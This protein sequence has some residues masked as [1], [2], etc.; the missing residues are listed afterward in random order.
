MAECFDI[1]A[2]IFRLDI[3][4][5]ANSSKNC[6]TGGT[7]EEYYV[8]DGCPTSGIDVEG[9]IQ[10]KSYHAAVRCCAND[11]E[12]CQTPFDCPTNK[13]SFD[14]AKFKCNEMGL[15]LCTKDEILSEVCCGTGG[16]CDNHFIWTSTSESGM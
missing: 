16:G 9:S 15:R 7:E 3:I 14:D 13:M 1:N 11:G 8:E 4:T 2:S 5:S 6:L 10:P 12:S